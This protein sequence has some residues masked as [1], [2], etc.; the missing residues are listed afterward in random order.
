MTGFPGL[1]QFSKGIS[2]LTQWTGREHKEMQHVFAGLIVSTV[3]LKVLRCTMA[4]INFIYLLQIHA[5][6]TWSIT[7]LQRVLED[8]HANKDIFTQ[9]GICADSN[10]PKIHSMSPEWLH[11]DFTKDAYQASN[12]HEYVC[13][14]TIW[15]G[16]QEVIAQFNAYLKWLS[17]SSQTT[18]DGI[19]AAPEPLED[20]PMLSA[21]HTTAKHPSYSRLN[22]KTI[23]H[24]FGASQFLT[25]LHSF[26]HKSCPS[27]T[28]PIFPNEFNY[29]TTYKVLELG[30]SPTSGRFEKGHK[31]INAN[32]DTVL[33][34]TEGSKSAN[35]S[36]LTA[37]M[38]FEGLQVAQIRLIFDL[39]DHLQLGWFTPFQGPHPDSHLY[40]VS[41]AMH[42][43]SPVA[44]IVPVTQIL[45]HC[46]LIPCTVLDAAT[47][48]FYNPYI[49]LPEF[50]RY[51]HI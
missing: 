28:N 4:A 37:D 13:Q 33:V 48:F 19:E 7:S 47:S 16:H 36:D 26:I 30:D 35:A 38:P 1:R 39:P 2:F 5:H 43:H 50:C 45:R 49:S 29:F 25:A 8:F 40:S 3:E 20:E 9:A 17:Q 18:K 11:I 32:F 21:T 14:M 24:N 10:I 6:T 34:K 44:D 46:H 27:M 12:K 41:Q 31:D 23:V 15:L 22:I 51:N 42:N